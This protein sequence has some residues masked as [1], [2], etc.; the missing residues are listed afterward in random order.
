MVS[1]IMIGFFPAG[2]MRGDWKKLS[3]PSTPVLV[4]MKLSKSMRI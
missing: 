1:V 4:E 2:S 3:L